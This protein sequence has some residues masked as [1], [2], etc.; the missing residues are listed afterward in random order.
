MASK[1]TAAMLKPKVLK[2]A[3]V[4][5]KKT[6]PSI[7]RRTFPETTTGAFPDLLSSPGTLKTPQRVATASVMITEKAKPKTPSS[8]DLAHQAIKN[9]ASISSKNRK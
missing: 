2:A 9:N 4:A 6:K 8:N 5:N 1:K 3:N 7:L